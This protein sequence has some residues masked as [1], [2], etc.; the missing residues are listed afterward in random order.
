MNIRV[1]F[2]LCLS[3]QVMVAMYALGDNGARS[4][5]DDWRFLR[6]DAPGGEQ[7]AFDDSAWRTLDVPHDWSIEDLPPKTDTV[8]ELDAVT[9][10]WLF[11]KGDDSAW[12][13]RGFNDSDWQKVTLP[14]A[15][16]EHSDYTDENVYGWFRR[17]VDIPA[18]L[19][20]R[21]FILLM[22]YID[23]VDEVFLN[24]ERIGGSGSFPPGYQTAYNVDRRYRVPASLVRGDGTDVLA[25]RVFDS[26]GG[27][28][29]VSAGVES[30][31]IGPFD[32][33]ESPSKHYNGN[34]VGGIGWY[35][36]HFTL[37]ESGK[38]VAVRFDGVYRNA[39]VWLNGN[40]LGEH[41]YGYTAFEFDLTPYLKEAGEENVLAVKVRN[42]GR[43]TRWYSGS[44][45]YR[46]VTLSVTDP[47]HIPWGGVFITTPE[48]SKNLALVNVSSE[49]KNTTV[50][51]KNVDVLIRIMD[52]DGKQVGKA[53][54]KLKLAAN[55]T[56]PVEQ[57]IKVN[58]PALWSVDTPVMYTA[59]VEVGYNGEQAD[60]VS[61]PFGIRSLEFSAEKGFLLNGKPLLLKGGCIHH[62][63]G[64]LGAAAIDR[65]EERK[66]ELLKANGYNAIR[67]AHNPPSAALLD[68]CDRLGMLVIDEA[69]DQWH[70]SKENN[71]QDYHGFFDEWYEH[72][73]ASMVRRDRNHPSVI[74]WSIGNEIPEQY[75][76]EATQKGLREA[77]LSH[78]AT[79]PITQGLCNYLNE[80]MDPGF[81]YL[82]IGGYN[83]MP[84]TY[85]RDHERFPNRVMYGS[86]SYPKQA[87]R[88]WQKVEELPYVIGD[89]VWT[90]MD[91][92]GEAGIGHALMNNESTAGLFMPW[93]Y[94]N[95]WCGDLDLC[96][97]KKAPSFYRDVVWR[98][99]ELEIL[100]HEPMAE[101]Q[102]ERISSW[103][104]PNEVKS[105]NWAGHEGTPLQVNVYSRCDQVRLELNGATIGEQ[106]VSERT[107]LTATFHV[108]YESG[109]LKA[110]GI[111]NG[112]V[113]AE[114]MLRTTGAPKALML[115]ADRS[116][117]RG[118]RSDLSYV[119]V[120]VVDENGQ[121]V[122]TAE[123]KV[124][125][126]VE[127]A[128]ELAGQAS[129]SPNKPAS[130][131]IPECTTFKGRC[132][133][134]L[135]PKGPEGAIT[136]K[137]EV[138][139]LKPAE[140]LVQTTDG[141]AMP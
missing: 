89:F 133:T 22:G 104:W 34:T 3:I 45:I 13:E 91:Y 62:D 15:W 67:T 50:E 78:D 41:P 129:G 31:R 136:L 27:G 76:A 92:L 57:T 30:E 44:G 64:A 122:P 66:I 101:G 113:V 134:I 106:S 16:E 90:A 128:G 71:A 117:I 63:N 40:L 59:L 49:I 135:R 115:T 48:I 94:V 100:V 102:V 7:V 126:T 116:T 21:E 74:M 114:T 120:E 52:A 119:T 55:A 72:D 141:S 110:Y 53:G 18:D 73:I 23:D 24:G 35:R 87:L 47:V 112:K 36:K 33:A 83:Y 77:A 132:I 2:S 107:Q 4:F 6:G 9:G 37:D 38:Q 84:G 43:S 139:G 137:A 32:A 20:G 97:F 70:E 60:T 121:R 28:G 29:I 25:V 39:Q 8:P 88:Y 95:A 93:P 105:W 103:G 58:Q 118:D 68:A 98:R 124:N 42:T 54:H 14:A 111:K 131:Q 82:D 138:K 75:R 81:N 1:F 12:S 5:D 99:S 127:G 123:L 61:V 86:E 79:R 85:E 130:H 108:P 11:Q 19:K 46:Q 10:E 17:K 140:I 109:E 56:Q 96:G 26:A 69:F 125:F 51:A 80:N 65:A